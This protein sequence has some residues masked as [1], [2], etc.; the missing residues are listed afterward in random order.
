MAEY[1]ID[2]ED[3]L[4]EIKRLKSALGRTPKKS[5]MDERGEYSGAV[6]LQRFESWGVALIEAGCEPNRAKGIP[7]EY[8]KNELQQ[9]ANEIDRPPSELDI[10]KKSVF[11]PETFR[12]RFGST[13]E[14]RKAAGMKANPNY[15]QINGI[16]ESKLISALYELAAELSRAPTTTEINEKCKYSASTYVRRFGSIK[17]AR[18]AAGF[19]EEVDKTTQ[20]ELDEDRLLAEIRRIVSDLGHIPR[21]KDIKEKSQYSSSTFEK[22]FG[23][24]SEAIEAAGFIPR[25]Y[26][27]ADNNTSEQAYYGSSWHKKRKEALECDEYECQRCGMG[28]SEHQEAHGCGLHVHHKRP[29]RKFENKEEAHRLSNLQTL[30]AECHVVIERERNVP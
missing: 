10:R 9:L 7:D 14:A 25:N 18:W 1:K 15:D 6:Y 27:K 11:A 30:C 5:E 24:W 21:R 4:D 3:L 20:G 13:A 2:K 12:D 22:K 29:F 23:S 28:E 16:P 17:E 26:R 8:L 19:R